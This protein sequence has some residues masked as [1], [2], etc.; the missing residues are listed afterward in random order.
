MADFNK[1]VI[2]TKSEDNKYAL[3]NE[4]YK[5]YVIDGEDLVRY[6]MRNMYVTVESFIILGRS[7]QIIIRIQVFDPCFIMK[8]KTRGIYRNTSH[9][10]LSLNPFT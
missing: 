6:I 7:L 1:S 9:S 10:S 8:K 4:K 5:F 2:E 3:N